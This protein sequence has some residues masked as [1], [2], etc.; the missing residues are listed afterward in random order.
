MATQA[1]ASQAAQRQALRYRVGQGT[2]TEVLDDSEIDECLISALR[3]INRLDPSWY[4]GHFSAVAD[5]QRYLISAFAPSTK[6]GPMQVFWG[7]TGSEGTCSTPGIFTS[8]G[9]AYSW[10]IRNLLQQGTQIFLDESALE[11]GA[12]R[13]AVL[14]RY[15]GGKGWEDRDGYVWLDPVPTTPVEVYYLCPID[16]FATALATDG[17]YSEALMDFATYRAAQLLSGKQSEVVSA[18]GGR[19]TIV[20]T[21]GGK[22]YFEIADRALKSFRERMAIAPNVSTL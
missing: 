8:L 6:N 22:I 2:S 4:L 14:Q 5:Q 16:R 19:G 1:Y 3:E 20:G 15:L 13:Y 7:P 10:M 17:E 12:R 21:S 9:D 11:I 18:S